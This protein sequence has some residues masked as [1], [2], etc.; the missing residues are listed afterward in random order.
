MI[1]ILYILLTSATY[2]LTAHA[3]IT[4]WLWRRYP[5]A[6]ERFAQCA[7]CSGA[8]YGFFWGV[9]GAWQQWSFLG[10]PGRAPL[11]I[12]MIGF[13][14][15]VWTP[16]VAHAQLHALHALSASFVSNEEIAAEERAV[17]AREG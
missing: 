1:V 2:Y 13:G 8:W 12:L 4:S 15:V 3:R 11:T 10:L 17:T 5:P 14:S 16:I 6:V 9:I 7:A